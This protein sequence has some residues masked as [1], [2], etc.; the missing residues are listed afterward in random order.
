MG[1]T[2]PV[3]SGGY[4]E[5]D[6]GNIV[7]P[8]MPDGT[9]WAEVVS[10]TYDYS[11]SAPGYSTE[12]GVVS[13]ETGMTTTLDVSLQRPVI[14][15]DPTAF[16]VQV[17]VGEPQTLPL[18]V[19]NLGH[20]PLDFEI[21][22]LPPGVFL[23]LGGPTFQTTWLEGAV[24]VD[25]QVYAELETKGKTEF[26]VQL[27]LQADLSPAYGIQDWETRGQYVYDAL[28][29]ATAAQAPIIAYAQDHG[30]AYETRLSN[31]AVF[32]K[33]ATLADVDAL[34]A[35]ADVYRIRANHVYQIED[36]ELSPVPEAWGW[37]LD[38]L[39]PDAGLY[40]MQAVQVW[41]DYGISGQGIVVGNLDTGVFYQHEAL[42]QQY[43]G[44]NGDGT[45]D[46]DFNW[47]APTVTATNACDGAATAPCDYNDHGSGTVGIMVGETQG[48][49][50]QIGIA[51]GA[52]WIACMGCDSPPS[53][54]SDEAL[55]KCADWMV[56]PCPI[57]VDPGD[58]ACDPS[59]RPHVINNS[60]G[61]EGCRDWYQTY[62]E[63][64][65]AAG[66]FPAFS[67]GNTVAC[68]AV[69]APGDNP[70][71][72]GTAAH[73]AD[74]G[75][76]YAGGP[77]CWFA[78]P[79]CDP[80]AHE[81]DPH[82]NAP[83]FGRTA[84]NTQAEY[85]ELSG[86]SGASPHT[87]GCVALMWAANPAL[88][89]DME[90]TFTILEQSADRTS[91]QAWAGGDCGKPTCAGTDTY[92]NYEYGWGYLD[93]YAAVEWAMSLRPDLP[94]VG[95]DPAMGTVPPLDTLTIDVSFTCVQTGTYTGTLYLMHNDPCA[96]NIQIPLT[97]ECIE[98]LPD[99]YYIYL[100]IIV[101]ND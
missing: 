90:T 39:D 62:I 31:N 86:T 53:G 17:E 24:E 89:G 9:F 65:R 14:D 19:D 27:R 67:A 60:W 70:P 43:R 49:D 64:W 58:P 76:L 4:V 55:T 40:G 81:V 73:A 57:G 50:E 8:V 26:F 87:A 78:E 20:L 84:G 61:G 98:P 32:V 6:P 96:A 30:L 69:G 85:W 75:N 1:G 38:E 21:L 92:P 34:A 95:V 80:D 47:Y 51:P 29:A 63:A 25:P 94:W 66:Q 41:Q 83:S 101:K 23:P 74:G 33:G 97:L 16:D 10:R 37:N 28:R 22:D 82:L 93:C 71:A 52:Q 46:H 13:V 44:N 12:T 100:P 48:M 45:F 2:D 11:A 18:T 15:V 42:V 59:L 36:V 91:T 7:I 56:A 99:R 79:S 3:C 77:S 5:L 88:I 68:G 54:C 72:F 35:R